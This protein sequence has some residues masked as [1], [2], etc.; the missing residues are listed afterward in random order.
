MPN[1]RTYQAH[2]PFR[3]PSWRIDRIIEI[4]RKSDS[5]LMHTRRCSRHDDQWVRQAKSFI[6]RWGNLQPPER[7]ALFYAYEICLRSADEPETAFIL[8]VRLL[9]RQDRGVIAHAMSTIPEAV[10][11]YEALFYNIND[12]LDNRDWITTQCLMPALRRHPNCLRPAHHRHTD[13]L[14]HQSSVTA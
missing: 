12:R 10:D 5:P 9:A 14:P 1:H 8:E 7:E 3:R 4:T 6:L 13:I 2:S 11:W